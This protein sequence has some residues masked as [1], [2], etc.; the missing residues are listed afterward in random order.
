M[1]QKTRAMTKDEALEKAAAI[2]RRH[3]NDASYQLYLFGSWAK[4]A[5]Y[6]ES[7]IDLAILGPQP[8]A[9]ALL[10]R[11]KEDIAALPTLRRVDIVDLRA[12]GESFRKNVL[13]HAKLV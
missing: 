3:I 1:Q 4:G 5:A 11:I 12:A 13:A 10:R 8:L 9:P 6:P 2:I 7:D